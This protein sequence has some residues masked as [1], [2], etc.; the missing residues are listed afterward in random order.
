MALIDN[1]NIEY[2]DEIFISIPQYTRVEHCVL[3]LGSPPDLWNAFIL[4]QMNVL[5]GGGSAEEML[6]QV[7]EFQ[8]GHSVRWSQWLSP[9]PP[10]HSPPQSQRKNSNVEKNYIYISRRAL[11]I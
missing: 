1:L 7:L 4:T 2:E 11:W 10:Q 9:V 6:L 5:G 8:G 3:A